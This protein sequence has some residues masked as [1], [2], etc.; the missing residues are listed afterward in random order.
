M[1]CMINITKYIILFIYKLDVI[2]SSLGVIYTTTKGLLE[3]YDYK[4]HYRTLLLS[5]LNTIQ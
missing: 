4:I 1:V 3:Y 5:F 2:Y